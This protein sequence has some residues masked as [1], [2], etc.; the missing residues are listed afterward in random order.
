ML[1]RCFTTVLGKKSGILAKGVAGA[2][3]LTV[4]NVKGYVL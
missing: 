4:S 2:D 1:G 3:G